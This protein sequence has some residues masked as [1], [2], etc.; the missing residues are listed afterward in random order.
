M[1]IQITT[2]R[3]LPA[4]KAFASS[5]GGLKQKKLA[6]TGGMVFLGLTSITHGEMVIPR[7]DFLSIERSAQAAR[8]LS[9]ATMGANLEEIEDFADEIGRVG[10]YEACEAWI[11]DQFA[12]SRGE[13]LR[14]R[15]GAMFTVDSASTLNGVI[16]YLDYG[17][18]DQAL[19]SPEQL[20]HRMAFSLSQIFVVSTDIWSGLHRSPRWK[21]NCDYYD[22]LADGAFGSHRDLLE[23]VTYNPLMGNYLSSAQNGKGDPENGIF[24]DEN[25]GREVM[26]LF[27]CGVFS[28]RANG[29]VR[30]SNGVELENYDSADIFEVSKVFTGLS[31]HRN[32]SFAGFHTTPFSNAAYMDKPM[33]MRADYHDMSSK[34]LLDGTVLPAGQSGEQDI[35]D[36]LDVLSAHPSTAPYMARLLI[37]RFTTSN[38]S[39]LYVRRVRNAWE[40]SDGDF[41][42]VLKAILLDPE[43][44]DAIDYGMSGRVLVNRVFRATPSDILSGRVKEPILKMTQF[45]KFFGAA[46]E[47]S[48][49]AFRPMIGVRAFGQR[50]LNAKSVFNFYAAEYAPGNGPIGDYRNSTNLDIVS[51]EMQILA[52]NVIGEFE[53]LYEITTNRR[54]ALAADFGNTNL[55]TLDHYSRHTDNIDIF[56]DRLD[57]YLCNG[58]MPYRVN[59][60]LKGILDDANISKAQKFDR[61]AALIVNSAEFSFSH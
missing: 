17:F 21:I 57:L 47:A 56:I 58:A 13:S 23:A 48:D 49:G 10:Y 59:L 24:P 38:P 50:F 53:R 45:Y 51:P 31:K 29:T 54:E 15:A 7:V 5:A 52:S 55:E 3:I 27:S 41:K 9:Q 33:R 32:G 25:Y 34:V 6:L 42:A 20:R 4:I 11:D 18:W 60:A 1:K 28:L 37:K 43:T 8:F 39:N 22:L 30:T 2:K 44:R 46:T 61:A 35:S 12:L 36:T 16:E 19:N 26:Q 14:D 40:N